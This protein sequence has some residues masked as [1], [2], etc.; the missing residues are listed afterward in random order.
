[1]VTRI[2]DNPPYNG[3]RQFLT[4]SVIAK[5]LYAATQRTLSTPPDISMIAFEQ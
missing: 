2:D 4:S 1:V 3:W 5:S